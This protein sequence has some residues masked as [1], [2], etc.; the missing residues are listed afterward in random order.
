V[1]CGVLPEVPH[2]KLSCGGRLWGIKGTKCQVTCD[3][4]YRL[5]DTEKHEVVCGAENTWEKEASYCRKQSYLINQF[6]VS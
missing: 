1:L 2:G 6:S 3:D 5:E 4:G